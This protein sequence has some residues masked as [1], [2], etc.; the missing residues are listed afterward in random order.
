MIPPCTYGVGDSIKFTVHTFKPRKDLS[1][2]LPAILARHIVLV[3][4][5]NNA[6]LAFFQ[7]VNPTLKPSGPIGQQAAYNAEK[8]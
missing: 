8:T 6:A 2:S 5:F 1:V 4:F 3:H 7:F